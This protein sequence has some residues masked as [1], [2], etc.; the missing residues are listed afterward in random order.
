MGYL[1]FSV[2]SLLL[3]FL[4]QSSTYSLFLVFLPLIFFFLSSICFLFLIF[5]YFSS[6]FLT[7]LYISYI[8]PRSLFFPCFLPSSLSQTRTIGTQNAVT[9]KTESARNWSFVWSYEQLAKCLLTGCGRKST[10]RRIA[11]AFA[12]TDVLPS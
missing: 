3:S 4:I 5:L 6:I 1:F 10:R 9:H 8:F 11:Y 12:K 7:S 2:Y